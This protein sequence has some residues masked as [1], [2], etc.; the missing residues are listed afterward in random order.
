MGDLGSIPGLGRS[1]GERKGY[2]LQYSGLENS[3][4]CMVHEVTKSQTRLNDF[5]FHFLSSEVGAGAM[6]CGVNCGD[7]PNTHRNML[8]HKHTHMT[9]SGLSRGEFLGSKIVRLG[10]GDMGSCWGECQ[11]P[12]PVSCLFSQLWL[13]IIHHL[14]F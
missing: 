5:H 2:S 4:D 13:N 12:N 6:K 9:H 8:T 10:P 11:L 1:P 7:T 3:M 14:P